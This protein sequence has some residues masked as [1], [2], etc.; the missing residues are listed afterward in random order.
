[1]DFIPYYIV[2]FFIFNNTL[3]F[4]VNNYRVLQ[5][6]WLILFIVNYLVTFEFGKLFIKY[7][8][9]GLNSSRRRGK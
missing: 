8:H 6:H 5:T 9:K 7:I 4:E 3:F 2:C 1:M